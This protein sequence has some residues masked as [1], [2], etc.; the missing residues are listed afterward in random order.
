VAGILARFNENS[1]SVISCVFGISLCVV[2]HREG[3][4]LHKFVKLERSAEIS[5]SRRRKSDVTLFQ[6]NIITRHKECVTSTTQIG[7]ISLK[8]FT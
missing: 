8:G 7:F 1:S 2:T 5:I 4:Y 3:Q 6:D